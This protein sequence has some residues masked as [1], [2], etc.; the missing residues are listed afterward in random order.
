MCA[1]R[2]GVLLT[3]TVCAVLI[4]RYPFVRVYF[5]TFRCLW[6]TRL[7][8]SSLSLYL[9]PIYI[10]YTYMGALHDVYTY[11]LLYPQQSSVQR[12][13]LIYLPYIQWECVYPV[14]HSR[15]F[16][17]KL[18]N[19]VSTNLRLFF[20]FDLAHLSYTLPRSPRH[21]SSTKRN[22]ASSTI[23]IRPSYTMI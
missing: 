22:N 7:D 11:I 16:L 15:R 3:S 8:F 19:S 13:N 12:Y 18:H 5:G 17:Y 1:R 23:F 4:E 21:S 6:S 9:S 14:R 20:F 2:E 10:L